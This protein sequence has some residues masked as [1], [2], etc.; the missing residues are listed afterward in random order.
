M[1]FRGDGGDDGT[2]TLQDPLWT[3]NV[4]DRLQGLVW[5]MAGLG[6][7]KKRFPR[8]KRSAFLGAEIVKLRQY[9]GRYY[10]CD[11]W[12]IQF[13]DQ[14]QDE[15]NDAGIFSFFLGLFRRKGTKPVDHAR[16]H[17]A[18]VQ[19]KRAVGASKAALGDWRSDGPSV[20]PTSLQVYSQKG[21]QTIWDAWDSGPPNL[22]IY[23]WL[24]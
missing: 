20:P 4:I 21:R 8:R 14:A 9:G 12:Q 24:S 23:Y 10:W 3:E 7:I 6:T 5:A 11:N 18:L 1:P 15:H 19:T 17:L 16:G 13:L 2:V 22:E